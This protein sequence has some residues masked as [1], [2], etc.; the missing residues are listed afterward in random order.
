LTALEPLVSQLGAPRAFAPAADVITAS[1]EHGVLS[2]IVPM[3]E[4]PKPRT[5]A[6]GEQAKQL[7][8]ANA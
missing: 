3:P 6:I 4:R 1:L 2:L 5:I 8:T 7:E